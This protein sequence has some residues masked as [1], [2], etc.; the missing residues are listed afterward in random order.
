MKMQS[1]GNYSV[2]VAICEQKRDDSVS[3]SFA[4]AWLLL[5]LGIYAPRVLHFSAFMQC[6]TKMA[7][8][9]SIFT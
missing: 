5:A 8:G 3:L 1:K 7:V 6:F 2:S 9:V 4:L